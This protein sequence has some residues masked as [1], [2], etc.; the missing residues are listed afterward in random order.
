M[1]DVDAEGSD[2]RENVLV[3]FGFILNR[4]VCEPVSAFED[5]GRGVALVDIGKSRRV[6][7]YASVRA[8]SAS[9]EWAS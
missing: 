5:D 1:R 9:V 3:H 4:S 6:C 7:P 8:V 2:A